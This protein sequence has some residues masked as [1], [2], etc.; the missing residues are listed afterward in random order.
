M[1]SQDTN[2][3]AKKLE[4]SL[5]AQKEFER[6]IA[7]YKKV[8]DANPLRLRIAKPVKVENSTV[9]FEKMAGWVNVR[10]LTC[11]LRVDTKILYY[12]GQAIAELH[13]ALN[14]GLGSLDENVNI[15]GD[16]WTNNALY[17]PSKHL[18]SI[19]DFAPST[20][21]KS[22]SYSHG[23]I[24]R[25]LAHVIFSL[26]IKYPVHKL[27]LLARRKNKEMSSR[28]LAGYEQVIG[29]RVTS[30]KLS[31][32]IVKDIDFVSKKVFTKKNPISRFVWTR[33][34]EQAKRRYV[35]QEV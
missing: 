31:E 35:N 15:H 12:V 14:Q 33:I 6:T 3:F 17:M 30:Q 28:F 7:V 9:Y 22:E 26:E 13:L 16:F 24:Y 8:S 29:Q 5:M 25:D 10:K 23:L 32:H 4:S 1:I 27:Y 20:Y 34:F 21:N 11:K 18:V 19:I 2:L